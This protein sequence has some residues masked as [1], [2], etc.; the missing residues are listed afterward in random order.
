MDISKSFLKN[1]FTSIV[2]IATFSF[3]DTFHIA[4]TGSDSTG[5][6]SEENPFATIAYTA[7]TSICLGTNG[8]DTLIVWPGTYNESDISINGNPYY[9]P[10]YGQQHF[11]IASSHG[12]DSTFIHIDDQIY[13]AMG[14][15]LIIDRLSISNSGSIDQGLFG[16]YDGS[17]TIQNSLIID[18]YIQD[19]GFMNAYY[20][21]TLVNNSGSYDNVG[22]IMNNC[23]LYNNNLEISSDYGPFSWTLLWN[24]NLT[25]QITGTG[26]IEANPLFCDPE[27]GDYTLAENSPAVG[28][29]ENGVNMGALG[30]GCEALILAPVLSDINDQQIEEDGDLI[31]DINA[32]SDIGASMTFYAES[33]TSSVIAFVEYATLILTP[34]PDWYGTANVTVMI[35]DENDLSDTTDFTLT[36]TPVND[37][38]EDFLV[39]SPTVSDTFS[40]HVDSDTAI[41]FNWEESYDVDSDVTYTLTIELEFFGNTYTDVHEDISDTTISISSNS[42]DALLNVTSQDIATLTYYVNSSDGEYMVASDVG[43]FVLFR[44]ALGVN[45]GLSVPVV[46]ALHQNYPNPFN[47]TT[48]IRYDLPEDALVSINIY[49]LMGRSIKSLV[50]SNQPAGYRSIQWDAT[51]NYGESVS[52]GMYI[53]TIQTGD[54]RATKKMV[55]LK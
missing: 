14:N 21:T 10:C 15:S 30:V 3:S 1:F 18:S 8:R 44:A 9:G 28:A 27:N 50:N 47:P 20:N 46:Y 42:L 51:N 22:P 25:Y 37:S 54:F 19:D 24:N 5:S 31:I 55:L 33:D 53:Y 41:V 11:Y 29:G 12:A 40:T 52:A 39:L 17:Y 4:T 26:I 49:D 35:T 2:F 38:P 48:Q 45:E 32:T 7:S 13:I 34:E 43:E 36:V 16:T 6:G 23:I